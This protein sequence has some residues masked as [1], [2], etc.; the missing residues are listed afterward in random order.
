MYKYSR[1]FG[2]AFWLVVIVDLSLLIFQQEDL[3][4]FTK[5]LLMPLLMLHY[6]A[7]ANPGTVF[8]KIMLGGL[9]FSWLGDLFLMKDSLFIPGLVSFLTAHIFYILY[10][11]KAGKPNK[12]LIQWQPLFG[13]PVLVY[14]LVF[15]SLLFPFLD[16]LRIPVVVYG[17]AISTMLLAAINLIRRIDRN[18]AILFLQGAIQFVLSDSLLAV[19]KFAFPFPYLGVAVMLTYCSAQF[20]LVRGS[21]RHLRKW[22]PA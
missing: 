1:L 10:F 15:L 19:N 4:L 13:I 12:G 18:A 8:K 21:V 22:D 16:A 3:R 20:L 11:V 9:F 17:V 14:L 2:Y 7:S 6:F 5:P